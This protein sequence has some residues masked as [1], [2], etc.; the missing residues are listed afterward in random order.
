LHST[1]TEDRLL[2]DG[3]V[4]VLTCAIAG[5]DCNEETLRGQLQVAVDEYDG[6]DAEAIG[7]ALV[8]SL[9]EDPGDVRQLEALLLL[10]LAHPEILGTY[11]ISLGAEGRRLCVLLENNGEAGRARGM[12]EL[13]ATELPKDREVQ[14]DLASF[15]RRSGNV[16]ELVERC[17]MRAEVEAD[18]GRI[19]GA[20]SS[21]QEVLLHD[22][23][24]RDVAKR[25]RDL[26]FAEVATQ[27]AVRRR[28]RLILLVVAVTT[29]VTA[30][31]LRE[32]KIREGYAAL[33]PV[34]INDE[35]ALGSRISG[36]DSLIASNRFWFGMFSVVDERSYLNK[37]KENLESKL[38]A[39]AR[40]KTGLEAQRQEKAESL[41][42]K[43]ISSVAAGQLDFAKVQF[44]EALDCSNAGWDHRE[45][46]EANI[47][48]I[49]KLLRE[50][51]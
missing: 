13:L 51:E 14:Q 16:D 2:V 28:N 50:R 39:A 46:I 42:L 29:T 5:E 41:R 33:P 19:S 17:L 30:L 31:F 7:R 10:S 43:A 49:D 20:I 9:C 26:R 18:A 1:S 3:V 23:S 8:E 12:L 4:D 6:R 48:A 44:R 47:A 27:T 45:R 22:Q 25:I 34:E 37:R 36:I 40:E 38:V 32:T 11:H 15:M 21:L 24:R 35:A